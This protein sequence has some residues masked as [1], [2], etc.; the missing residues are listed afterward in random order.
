MWGECK[1]EADRPHP[2]KPESMSL[3]IIMAEHV[4]LYAYVL[5]PGRPILIELSSFLVKYT[6]LM[7][8]DYKPLVVRIMFL[9]MYLIHTIVLRQDR[10][11]ENMIPKI[12]FNLL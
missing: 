7:S 8:C 6:D 3:K 1:N 11:C 2:F 12:I 9:S 5:P 10:S 4:E